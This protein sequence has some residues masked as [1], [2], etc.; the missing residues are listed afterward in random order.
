MKRPGKTER[1]IFRIE[2]DIKRKIAAAAKKAKTTETNLLREFIKA[3]LLI[4]DG[5]VN[6][7]KQLF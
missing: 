3:G 1:L 4:C 7:S 5:F 6:Q 2:P